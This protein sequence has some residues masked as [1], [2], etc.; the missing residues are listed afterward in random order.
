MSGNGHDTLRVD[1]GE[2]SYDILVGGRLLPNAGSI[3]EGV[4]RSPRVV[5][6]T[7]TAVADLH[8]TALLTSLDRHGIRHD[9][10]SL[11]PGE[12]TKCFD[13]LERLIGRLLDLRIDRATTLVALGGGVIGDIAGF[14]ASI[15]LRGI[16]FVQ[17]PTTLLSQVDSSVGGKT[18]I[19]TP[20]G[21]NLVG[22]FYQ[23]RLVLADTDVLRTLP[24]RELRA[25]YAEVVKYGL[26]D[27]PDFF[28]WLD[29]HGNEVLDGDAA[30]VRHAVVKSCA[31]KARVV[32]EDEREAD[33][34]ALLNLG[35]T[36]AH[37]LEAEAGYEGDLLHGEAVS[38]GMTMAFDFSVRLGLCP[39][40]DAARVRGHLEETGLPVDLRSRNRLRPSPET[41]VSR[42][43]QDKKASG[44]N[45]T[46]V[47]ARGIGRSFVARDVSSDELTAFLSEAVPA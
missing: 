38:I 3:L 10:I 9:T 1:L 31:A 13:E 33:K 5:V 16:D 22:T 46:L 32:G 40:G 43:R 14:A 17:I 20:H 6:V 30:A 37:A 41:L 11:P 4:L 44:G 15:A 26:I 47:L 19:N 42:M 36:F 23:P 7:D 24:G 25:G 27:E 35:H 12:A 2:R 21:K 28:D 34:R 39:P 8:L 18:G 29:R 45:L